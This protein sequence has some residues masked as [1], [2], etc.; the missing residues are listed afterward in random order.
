MKLRVLTIVIFGEI[1]E[2]KC[3]WVI[4]NAVAHVSEVAR[5]NSGKAE[6]VTHKSQ[7]SINCSLCF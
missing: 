2:D 4:T 7:M 3:Q 5:Q 6:Q 1:M